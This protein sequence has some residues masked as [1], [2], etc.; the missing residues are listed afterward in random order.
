MKKLNEKIG[1]I[2]KNDTESLKQALGL[3][4]I[5]PKGIY[6]YEG[7]INEHLSLIITTGSVRGF[8]YIARV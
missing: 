8:S 7:S 3:S 6:S 4:N 1:L 2:V 5:K